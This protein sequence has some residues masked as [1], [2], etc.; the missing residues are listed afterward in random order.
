MKMK[1]C[2][3]FQS[4][5]KCALLMKHILLD[6]CF[7]LHYA[8]SRYLS[9]IYKINTIAH[10]ILFATKTTTNQDPTRNIKKNK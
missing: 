6:L 10:P 2:R 7:V 4:I 1:L 5:G 9:I 8:T 3:H